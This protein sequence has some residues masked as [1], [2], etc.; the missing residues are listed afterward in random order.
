MSYS[1]LQG[2]VQMSFTKL[3]EQ[4]EFVGVARVSAAHQGPPPYEVQAF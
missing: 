2:V 1:L 3:S 4:V